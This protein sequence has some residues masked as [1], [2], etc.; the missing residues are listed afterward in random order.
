MWKRKFPR[1]GI[2][3]ELTL[4]VFDTVLGQFVVIDPV[5]LGAAG[6]FAPILGQ[7][8]IARYLF[9]Y[10]EKVKEKRELIILL[11]PKII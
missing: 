10:E 6:S 5:L 11:K 4:D 8:P 2:R 7:I 9:G 3:L 1:S